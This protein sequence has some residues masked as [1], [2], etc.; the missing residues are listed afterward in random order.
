ME[1]PFLYIYS[2]TLVAYPLI[3]VIDLLEVHV[4][5]IITK[6]GLFLSLQYNLYLCQVQVIPW[7]L[8]DSNSIRSPAPRLDPNRTVF[9]GGLHGLINA[10]IIIT[11]NF[12]ANIT[13]VLWGL[14]L[15]SNRCLY[16]QV[17]KL[18]YNVWFCFSQIPW[19][20]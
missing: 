19:H 6:C 20:T 12:V 5:S 8:S 3:L 1:L 2:I 14:I 7:A 11:V 18:I 4:T 15:A 9:V 17:S 13:V 10:G 16:V